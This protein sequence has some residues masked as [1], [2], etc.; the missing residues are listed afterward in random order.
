MKSTTAHLAQGCL[1]GALIGDAAGAVLEF[2]GRAP[3]ED[4]VDHAL[5]LPGG[6]VW[7][8]APGQV[9]DDGELALALARALVGQEQYPAPEVARNYARWLRSH[10][11]DVGFATSNAMDVALD[12]PQP[13]LQMA[14]NA[15]THNHASKANGALMRSSPLGIW[16]IRL[17]EPDAVQAAMTDSA[18][19]HPNPSCQ[20]ANAAYVS[21]LR[22]LML[23]PGDARGALE[24]GMRALTYAQLRP[25]IQDG[26]EEVSG[27]LEDATKGQ[28]PPFHPLAG[29]VRIAFTHAFFHLDQ[30]SSFDEAL[31][32]TLRGGGDTDTNA[33]IVGAM[34][35]ALHGIDEI[36][37]DLVQGVLTSD[38]SLGHQRPQWLHPADALELASSLRTDA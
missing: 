29:F 28:L 8:V 7:K 34:I 5:T 33:C 27:W 19:S 17:S 22:H 21:A 23:H 6:G 2:L 31:R 13:D 30:R 20:S 25:G 15:S 14:R 32:T 24:A 37:H 11:F 26:V 12:D 9:T 36:D 35:G 10:P 16:S 4:E 1:I 38:R 3:T 18:L